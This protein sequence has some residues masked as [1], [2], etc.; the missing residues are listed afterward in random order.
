MSHEHMRDTHVHQDWAEWGIP[1]PDRPG[2]YLVISRCKVC[3]CKTFV[4]SVD[5]LPEGIATEPPEGVTPWVSNPME[6]AE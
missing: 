6:L 5:A 3:D 4:Y 1:D 2:K